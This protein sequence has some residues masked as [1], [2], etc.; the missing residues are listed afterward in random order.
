MSK[1]FSTKKLVMAAVFTALGVALAS[2]SIP[3]GA[4]KCAP[5]Q[6]FINV[7]CAVVLGPW[8]SV[9]VAFCIS[10][11]RNLIGTGTLLA[12]PGSMIGALLAGI[13]YRVF[14][15]DLLAVFGELVGTGIIGA[16]AAYLMASFIMGKSGLAVYVY[17][18]PFMISCAGGCV[19][20]YIAIKALRRT[21]LLDKL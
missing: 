14:R 10:L 16:F 6:H 17:V 19:L 21:K 9:C 20:A 8:Y 7:L 15:K 1:K 3:I 12:F 11:I 4:S 5:F 2:V 18:M 13:L